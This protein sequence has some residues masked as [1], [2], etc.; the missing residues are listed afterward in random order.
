[1]PGAAAA[2]VCAAVGLG[3]I[4][5]AF[6]ARARLIAA[7][8]CAAVALHALHDAVRCLPVTGPLSFS[9]CLALA[10]TGLVIV[11]SRQG[12][13]GGWMGVSAGAFAMFIALPLAQ[14]VGAARADYVR[15]ADA[16]VVLGARVYADGRPSLALADRVGTACVLMKQGLASRLIVSGG[17]G[18][19]V[20]DEPHVMRE[21]ALACGVPDAAIELDSEGLSTK[22]TAVNVAR[23]LRQQNQHAPPRVLV[24]S[25]DYHLART[26]MAFDGAGLVSLTVPAHETRTLRALPY[27]VAREVPG[28]WVYFFARRF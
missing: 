15:P 27:Y 10:T 3:L 4:S 17:P 2:L 14:I 19:G 18:D 23:M 28:F 21:I 12:K 6:F 5:A 25:H 8:C 26:R 7:A 24:V 20:M 22:D 13:A 1:M 16:V 9:T 11:H